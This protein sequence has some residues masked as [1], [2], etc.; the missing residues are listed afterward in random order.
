MEG[1][2]TTRY[3]SDQFSGQFSDQTIEG[4]LMRSAKSS[5]GLTRGRLRN[6]SSM[7]I[8]SD[9]YSHLK[10][11]ADKMVEM[12]GGKRKKR[13]HADL[14]QK[15]IEKDTQCFKLIVKWFFTH[16]PFSVVSISF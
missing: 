10:L 9:T 2:H 16:N 3:N 13:A 8:W 14:G 15:R 12:I 7:K 11:L 6:E 1:N 4:T 5:G